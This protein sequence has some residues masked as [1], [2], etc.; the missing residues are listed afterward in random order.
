MSLFKSFKHVKVDRIKH[1]WK[2][3]L[4]CANGSIISRNSAG[5]TASSGEKL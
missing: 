1:Q 2:N 3:K 5:I 4:K